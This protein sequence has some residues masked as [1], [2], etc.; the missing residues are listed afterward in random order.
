MFSSRAPA[1]DGSASHTSHVSAM[2]PGDVCDAVRVSAQVEIDFKAECVVGDVVECFG[3]RINDPAD[4]N[5]NGACASFFATLF[6]NRLVSVPD[7]SKPG[8]VFVLLWWQCSC[9]TALAVILVGVTE[10]NPAPQLSFAP[11]LLSSSLASAGQCRPDPKPRV[12][13]HVGGSAPRVCRNRPAAL[14]L[15][16]ARSTCCTCCSAA[17]RTAAAS[18]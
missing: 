10:A 13:W 11:R 16:Q 9:R 1:A 3:A 14:F 7:P 6:W 4:A 5:A 12:W 2:A 18:W 8:C 15:L 17:T